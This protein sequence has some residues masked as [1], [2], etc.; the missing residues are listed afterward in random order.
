VWR[1]RCGNELET[2]GAVVTGRL[3][4]ANL[5][6]QQ[7][8][9]LEVDDRED[10]TY[11]VTIN[12]RAATELKVI[13]AIDK[14]RQG[15]G[16]GEFPPIPMTFIAPEGSGSSGRM[17]KAAEKMTESL[18]QSTPQK[19]AR[20]VGAEEVVAMVADEVAARATERTTARRASESTSSDRSAAF[21]KA[22][23]SIIS[24]VSSGGSSG[25]AGA[26]PAAAKQRERRRS[27]MINPSDIKES[28]R[29]GS[30]QS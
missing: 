4:S 13:I 1:A 25:E 21:R 5:P 8:T 19:E 27:V 28:G 16:G 7:E 12:L 3:Q 26:A 23:D 9:N 20:L 10:G 15:G 14:E 18:R 2:G 17:K 22:G 11:Q 29:R 24:A 6:P 30:T